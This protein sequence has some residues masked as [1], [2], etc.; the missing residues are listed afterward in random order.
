VQPPRGLSA[1]AT[2]RLLGRLDPALAEAFRTRAQREGEDEALLARH[3]ADPALTPHILSVRPPLG[4][5][6]PS[7]L[8]RDVGIVRAGLEAGHAALRSVLGNGNR[9]DAGA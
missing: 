4:S 3:A 9:D 8:E 2:T 6:V 7:R 1:A 5:A